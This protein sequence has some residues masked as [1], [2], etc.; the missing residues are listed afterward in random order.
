MNIYKDA[1]GI[2]IVPQLLKAAFFF[3]GEGEAGYSS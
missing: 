3:G 1:K 2:F